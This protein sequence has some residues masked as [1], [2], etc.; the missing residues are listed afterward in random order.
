MANAPI[1]TTGR[2]TRASPMTPRRKRIPR[3]STMRKRSS[4]RKAGTMR[5]RPRPSGRALPVVPQFTLAQINPFDARAFGVKV[6]DDNTAMSST[7]TTQ[8]QFQFSTVVANA[9]NLVAFTPNPRFYAIPC[10]EGGAGLGTWTAVAGFAG[11]TTTAKFASIDASYSVARPVAH[12]IRIS[13]ALPVNTA[14]GYLHVCL[15]TPSRFA[16]TTWEVP[17]SLSQMIDQPGYQRISISSLTQCPVLVVNKFVGPSA[18]VYTGV[19]DGNNSATTSGV[20][21]IPMGWQY[22]CVAVSGV[23][24]LTTAIDIEN[25]CHFEGQLFRGAL[26]E[27]DAAA[28]PDAAVLEATASL[29]GDMNAVRPMDVFQTP[30]ASRYCICFILL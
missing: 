14:A 6:P 11:A 15:Y 7:F 9:S 3:R 13:S 27:N 19:N 23:A 20:P 1:N 25:I 17:L 12:A 18:W 5:T 28:A 21:A 30:I 24:A 26:N 4:T 29:V 2:I 16:D 10:T 8:D 22:I